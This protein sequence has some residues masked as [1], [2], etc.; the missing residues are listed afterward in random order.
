MKAW[1]CGSLARAWVSLIRGMV[2][3]ILSESS[4]LVSYLKKV[5]IKMWKPVSLNG[6]ETWSVALR[7]GNISRLRSELDPQENI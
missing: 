2:A 5:K 1:S 6:C 7:K 4:L 3:T